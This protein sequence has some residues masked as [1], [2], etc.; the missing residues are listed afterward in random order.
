MAFCSSCSGYKEVKIMESRILANVEPAEVF[1]Y[2]EDLTR[3][4]RESG[5]EAAV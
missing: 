4:P 1:H 5:N 3:I 2:F